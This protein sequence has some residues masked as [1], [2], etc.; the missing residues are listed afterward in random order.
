MNNN[1]L[2]VASHLV[3]SR[4]HDVTS[5]TATACCSPPGLFCCIVLECILLHRILYTLLSIC[6]LNLIFCPFLQYPLLLANASE[7]IGIVFF[8]FC[9]FWVS[10]YEMVQRVKVPGAK[11]EALS[12]ILE[13]HR[14][15]GEN[16]LKSCPLIFTWVPWHT[17]VPLK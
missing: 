1:L 6:M 8:F 2:Y 9:D 13:S 4:A 17:S 11:P 16:R 10:R 14:V 15:E 5:Q 7:S 3:R 12:L